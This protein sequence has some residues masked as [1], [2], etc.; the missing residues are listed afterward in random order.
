LHLAGGFVLKRFSVSMPKGVHLVKHEGE[1]FLTWDVYH[2]SVVSK[3]ESKIGTVK[4]VADNMFV[5]VESTH[6]PLNS[7]SDAVWWIYEKSFGRSI[8]RY[9]RL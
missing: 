8:G 3:L 5:A 7:R 1:F 4:K 6:P 2:T 9:G